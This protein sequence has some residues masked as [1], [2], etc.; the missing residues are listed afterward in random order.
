MMRALWKVGWF[1]KW[2]YCVTLLL[3]SMVTGPRRKYNVDTELFIT[4]L[5]IIAKRWKQP[6]CP[7]PER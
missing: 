5:F 1:F 4:G 7:S 6:N 3:C 2:T